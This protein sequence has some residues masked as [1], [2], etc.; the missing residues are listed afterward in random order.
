VSVHLS[1]DADFKG[2]KFGPDLNKQLWQTLWETDALLL[3]YTSNDEDWSYC[4]LECG[5]AQNPQS[6]NTTTVV[7]QCSD[8]VPKV[9]AADLRVNVRDFQHIKRF[10]QQLMT[11]EKFF[12]SRG[13]LAPNIQPSTLETDAKELYEKLDA[14]LPKGMDDRRVQQWSAWPYLRIEVPISEMES[15]GKAEERARKAISKEVITEQGVVVDTGRAAELFGLTDIAPR[16]VLKELLQKWRENFPSTEATWFD[17]CCEQMMLSAQREWPVIRHAPLRT[18]RGETEFTPVVS[19]TRRLPFAGVMHFDIY[20]Y[21]I[22]DP[23]AVPVTSRMLEKGDFF[24][25]SLAQIDPESVI[26]KELIA[27]LNAID[28]NRLP[29]FSTEDHPLYIV[30]RSMIEQFIASH[31]LQF[32]GGKDVSLL[33]LADLFADPKMKEIFEDTFIVVDRNATLSEV[34]DIMRKKPNCLDVFVTETGSRDERVLGWLSNI[35]VNR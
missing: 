33:T 16:H 6:P 7:L 9:F 32:T 20:F 29:I 14:V 3:V 31:A 21:D 19:R 24:S 13:A 5:V 15:V 12:R 25:K 35:M 8:D 1:S 2:P 4:M 34:K 10:T 18:P 22:S 28:R 30:H 11:D 23:S 27:E 26:L 17:S